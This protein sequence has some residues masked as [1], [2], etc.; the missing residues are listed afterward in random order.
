MRY[1]FGSFDKKSLPR[2]TEKIGPGMF[3]FS[4]PLHALTHLPD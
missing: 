1:K 3:E 4:R 2:T